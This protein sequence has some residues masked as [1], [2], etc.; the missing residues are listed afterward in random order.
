MVLVG[1]VACKVCATSTARNRLCQWYGGWWWSR[2]G[3]LLPP[4]YASD[5]S[6]FML[7]EI[8]AGQLADAAAVKLPKR[9]PFHVAL[10]L[11]YTGR[12]MNAAEAHR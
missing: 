5:H 10:D 9:I 11:L 1:L 8:R 12:C 2:A 6:S 4:D 3:S 7:P